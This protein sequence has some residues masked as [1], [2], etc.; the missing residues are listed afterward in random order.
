[1]SISHLLEDFSAYARGRP[2]SLTDVSLEEFKLEAFEKGYQAGWDDS[3]KAQSDAAGHISADLAQNLQELSFT[4]QE[5]YAAV[6]NALRPL[7]EQTVQQVLPKLAHQGLGA[8]VSELLSEMARD[9]GRQPVEMV[10]APQN[11]AALEAVI[12]QHEA[13]PIELRAE[14]SMSDGQVYLRF[15][16]AEREIDLTAVLDAIESVVSGFFDEQEKE[17][18]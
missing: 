13:L 8:Q 14:P 6:L 9:H 12:D 5:A 4:Y 11:A 17:T 15:G 3:A 16:E 7:I 10:T 2:V 1:M 18:A